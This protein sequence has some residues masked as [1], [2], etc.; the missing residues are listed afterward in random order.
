MF[1][2]E[3]RVLKVYEDKQLTEAPVRRFLQKNFL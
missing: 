3:T 1:S 2:F